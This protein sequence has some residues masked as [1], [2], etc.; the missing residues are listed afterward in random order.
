VSTIA[1]GAPGRDASALR[2]AVA[3]VPRPLAG[4]LAIT[5]VIG[6]AWALIVPPWQAPDTIDHYAYSESLATRFAL[7]GNKHRAALSSDEVAG[8]T[9]AFSS[10]EAFYPTV[11][12]PGG[13]SPAEYAA[14]LAAERKHPS[15]SNGGG[16]NSADSNPPLYYL[17]SDIPYLAFSGG[18]TFDRLYAIQ[19]WGVLLLL[20]T[21]VGGWLLAGEVLG[22][23]RMLQLVVAATAG[24]MPMV[25]FLSTSVNPDALLITL[26]TWAL[27]LG[28]RVITRAAQRRDAT[29]MC[30]VTAAAILTQGRAY[31]LVPPVLL[32]LALGWLRREPAARGSVVRELGQPLL[33]LVVPVLAWIGLAHA[34]HR[35]VTNGAPT[36]GSAVNLRQFLSYLWQFYLPRLPFLTRFRETP[37]LPL[38]DV[39]EH[40]GWAD[41]GW[42]SVPLPSVLYSALTLFSAVV[43]IPG[44][45][46]LTR[47]RERRQWAVI[48]FLALAVLS[49]LVLLNITD[50]L[51]II[52]NGQSLLQGRYLLPEVGIF[53]LAIA[54]VISRLPLRARGPSCGGVI[55]G[56]LLLQVVSLA[57]VAQ[58]YYT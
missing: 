32:A 18:T 8:E 11:V 46:L 14:Y 50:Y 30:G 12:K 13:W 34:L 20:L 5:L 31:A 16:T 39:W 23:R 37:G 56:L 22:R 3:V 36:G 15:R 17:F 1:E 27:W 52:A 21:V 45:A 9:Y 41:F 29:A 25:T 19:I 42:L 53:G 54:F 43:I 7:P 4:L 2:R 26:W 38:I 28:V 24:L 6:V 48:A 35:M 10:A 47:I 51:Q 49:M 57:V 33:A 44:A 40:T 55:A 58:T